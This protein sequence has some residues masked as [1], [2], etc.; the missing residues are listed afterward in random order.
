MKKSKKSL[1]L[2]FLLFLQVSSLYSQEEI[3]FSHE[4]YQKINHFIKKNKEILYLCKECMNQEIQKIRIFSFRSSFNNKIVVI[5]I[6]EKELLPQYIYVW[7][8][9][10]YQNLVALVKKDVHLLDIPITLED[11]QIP[12][13]ILKNASD[14]P[15]LT[16]FEKQLID[17]INLLRNN[18]NLYKEKL[19]KKLDYFRGNQFIIPGKIVIH[20]KEG[21]KAV[22]EAIEVLKQTKPL[23]QLEIKKELFDSSKSHVIDIGPKGIVSHYSSNGLSP[24]ERISK[25]GNYKSM[26]EVISFGIYDAEEIV[27][28][29]L[30]DDGVW[31]RGHRKNLLEKN[32]RY[33][34]ASCGEH[35]TYHFMCVVDFGE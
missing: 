5:K 3:S 6:N 29:F 21:Q 27:L 23:P 13:N 20:T 30:I 18:P 28:Q 34:G 1:I 7:N 15:F 26:G 33:V 17:A 32:F 19:E 25:L 35:K 31:D 4:E 9:D 14:I 10:K 24:S 11:N 16:Q 22:L 8:I 12:T 2:L